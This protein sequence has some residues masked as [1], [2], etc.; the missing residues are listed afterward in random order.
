MKLQAKSSGI[1][2]FVINLHL[3]SIAVCYAA[4]S[5]VPL[6]PLSIKPVSVSTFPLSRFPFVGDVTSHQ[7][8]VCRE[9]EYRLGYQCPEHG[10]EWMHGTCIHFSTPA[11]RKSWT[12]ARAACRAKHRQAD[13]VILPNDKLKDEV[14]NFGSSPKIMEHWIGLRSTSSSGAHSWVNG[15][16][17]SGQSNLPAG[18]QWLSRTGFHLA[19]CRDTKGFICQREAELSAYRFS[20]SPKI[21]FGK[22]SVAFGALQ[23]VTCHGHSRMERNICMYWMFANQTVHGT[24]D[25][26]KCGDKEPQSKLIQYS[27]YLHF[28]LKENQTAPCVR[29]S[30][31]HVEFYVDYPDLFD[32]MKMVCCKQAYNDTW[33]GYRPRDCSNTETMIIDR[34]QFLKPTL[35]VGSVDFAQPDPFVG[36]P[37]S[38]GCHGL[39]HKDMVVSLGWMNQM[40]VMP[41]VY[42]RGP[43][44]GGQS[45]GTKPPEMNLDV[46]HFIEG[47]RYALVSFKYNHT[48]YFHKS[49]FVCWFSN[50]SGLVNTTLSLTDPRAVFSRVINIHYAPRKPVLELISQDDLVVNAK[51]TT[52]IGSYD[53]SMTMWGIYLSTTYLD[54][55]TIGFNMRVDRKRSSDFRVKQID[56]WNHS[57]FGPVIESYVELHLPSYFRNGTLLC[58]SMKLP[59]TSFFRRLP[60]PFD[61]WSSVKISNDLPNDD[62]STVLTLVR[63]ITLSCM[64][65]P[66]ILGLFMVAANH[67]GGGQYS[68]EDVHTAY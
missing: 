2:V 25:E 1:F 58:Y 39:A 36:Q 13:L 35:S 4:S 5:K 3:G 15:S 52:I 23:V 40:M 32:G 45:F 60:E 37:G 26:A 51:C 27:T 61:F 33:K 53:T 44:T 14:F 9:A 47:F 46:A 8:K 11:E 59:R 22:K 65:A 55:I 6:S 50:S 41:W 63:V 49:L 30:R 68:S 24:Y 17:V 66:A 19:D 28:Y 43:H 18:C 29:R 10:W 57:T 12:D 62:H 20:E 7:H 67:K 21:E 31:V 64:V 38:V 54:L 56:V 16:V 34:N 48:W 42:V